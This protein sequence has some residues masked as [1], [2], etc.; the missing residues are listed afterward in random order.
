MLRLTFVCV[1]GLALF[2]TVG[3]GKGKVSVTGTVTYSDG[4][5]LAAG[6]V[7]FTDSTY[8][9]SGTVDS[10]GKYSIG[11]IS[12]T[13]GIKPGEYSVYVAGAI[14]GGGSTGTPEVQHVA[15]KYT[16]PATSGLKTSVVKGKSL[17]FDFTVERPGR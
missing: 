4:T 2:G 15:A 10:Q 14:T 12:T 11:E 6:A 7:I 13:D 17:V 5:P 8:R 3:C 16:D 9:A 1:L